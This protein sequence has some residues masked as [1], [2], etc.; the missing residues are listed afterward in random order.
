MGETMKSARVVALVGPYTTGKTTLMESMLYT[1]EAIHRR[2]MVGDQ[3]SVGDGSPESR[4]R[5]MSTEVS[6]AQATFMGDDWTILDCP[7]SV[8]FLQDAYDALMVADVAVVVADPEPER[9]VMLT[10]ILQFLDAHAIPHMIFINKVDRDG[11]TISIRAC[12]DALQTISQRPLVLRELPIRESGQISGYVDLVSERA[13]HYKPG[14]ASDLV[15]IPSDLIDREQQARQE[16]LEHLADFDDQLLENLLEDIT[17]PRADVY[18]D[19]KKELASDEVVPVFFGASAKDQG[20]RRLWKALRHETPNHDVTAARLGAP[21]KGPIASIFKTWHGRQTGKLSLLRVWSGELKDGV[22]IDSSIGNGGRISGLYTV[23]GQ[24]VSKVTTLSAGMVGAAGRLDDVPTG[25]LIGKK[26]GDG[27][28]WVEPMSPLFALALRPVH[29]GD[30]VKLSGALAK[31]SEEDPSLTVDHN[32]AS[33][34]LLL[35]GQGDIHLSVSIARLARLFHVEVTTE[36]PQ[37]AY[38]ETFR[39]GTQVQGRFKRQSG[40]HGQFG[41]VHLTITPLP[42]GEGF[43]FIDK[44]TGGAIPRNYIPAVE[45]G[46]I[47]WAARGP[48]GFP[49]VDFEVELTDGSYHVVDS[50]EAAFKSAAG[51]AM[52]DGAPQCSP[53]LLEPILWV[54]VSVPTDATSKAQRALAGRRGQILGF[55]PREG[56]Q[57]WDTVQAH[58]PQG[59]MHDLITELRS[60]SMGVGTFRW[61]F[62]HLR[63][64]SGKL[65]DQVVDERSKQ[66]ASV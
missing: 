49:V 15:E 39:S 55:M 16:M 42:R 12:L 64:V 34:E 11:T 27:V 2:G 48:L 51:V 44:V 22:S 1:A 24:E 20:V 46:V 43:R 29:Q 61:R 37:V 54:E 41:D 19:L 52:R 35:W 38:Q 28:E 10:P 9:A 30:D 47:E 53:V 26:V 60:L 58:V 21:E 18:N 23:Q 8:E 59:E 7:G 6:V 50:S 36:R 32:Q 40:G 25:A 65:A 3:S 56:W 5:S 45:A 31:L 33:N 14:E 4:D 13:Y 62:D 66:L 17:P 57:G 63:E